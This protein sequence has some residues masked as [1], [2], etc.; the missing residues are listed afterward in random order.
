MGGGEIQ[1][2]RQGRRGRQRGT[3]GKREKDSARDTQIGR[4]SGGWKEETEG[5]RSRE[6]VYIRVLSGKIGLLSSNRDSLK[7]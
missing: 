1:L 7:N 3:E 6:S 2:E 5:D 4:K